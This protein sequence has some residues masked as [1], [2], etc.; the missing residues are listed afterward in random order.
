MPK[1][2]GTYVILQIDTSTGEKYTFE[3]L[4]LYVD[5]FAHALFS[6]HGVQHLDTVAV[7]LTNSIEYIIVRLALLKLGAIPAF[8]NSL[9]RPSKCDYSSKQIIKIF[10]F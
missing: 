6:T 3:D 4:L 5:C 9:L 8:L 10:L 7:H 1:F 2:M